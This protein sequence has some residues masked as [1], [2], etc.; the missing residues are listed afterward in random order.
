V[1]IA[2]VLSIGRI[3]S[4]LWYGKRGLL[5]S[6]RKNQQQERCSKEHHP[7]SQK[8]N[9]SES[10]QQYFTKLESEIR[11]SIRLFVFLVNRSLL[12]C[13]VIGRIIAWA[14]CTFKPVR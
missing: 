12:F 5:L 11:E 14:F 1:T 6:I 9:D 10:L 3:E 4:V 13:L 8:T 7:C 2:H